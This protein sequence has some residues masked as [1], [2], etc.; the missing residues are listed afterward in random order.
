MVVSPPPVNPRE[1]QTLCTLSRLEKIFQEKHQ[2]HFVS[3]VH[4]EYRASV[5]WHGRGSSIFVIKWMLYSFI[6]FSD[7]EIKECSSDKEIIKSWTLSQVKCFQLWILKSISS[8]F[9]I[10]SV[11]EQGSQDVLST[12]LEW[13]LFLKSFVVLI[14]SIIESSVPVS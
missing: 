14:Q 8:I 11:S 6:R 5:L 10:A 13:Y 4:A 9:D 7:Q 12:G 3:D 2:R 1:H